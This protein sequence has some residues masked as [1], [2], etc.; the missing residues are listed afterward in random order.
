M[1]INGISNAASA[2]KAFG[3]K[4]ASTA[5]NI[6]NSQSKNY[7]KSRV[8]LEEQ[9]NNQGVK[10]VVSRVD[11][12]GYTDASGEE[13]SNVDIVEEIASTITTSHGIKANVKSIKTMDEMLGS[14][15]NIIE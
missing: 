14:I 10:A 1:T 7:K 12:P 2:I 15:I 3:T 5:D 4:M 9:D 11:T 8:T 6:A 13:L